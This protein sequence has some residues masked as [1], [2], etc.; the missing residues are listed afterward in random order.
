MLLGKIIN[1]INFVNMSEIK[2]RI[3][4][5]CDAS[6]IANCHWHVRD[7]YSQGIFLSLGEGFLKAYYKV[8]LNEPWEVVICAERE[9]GKIIGFCSNNLNGIE[10]DKNFVKHKFK[11]GLAA[12]RAIILHPHLFKECWIR[13]KA[14]KKASGAP[15]LSSIEG[16]RGEYWC[17]LKNDD[18]YK[19]VEMSQIAENIIYSLGYKD[20]SFEV[21][22][23]NKQVFKYHLKVAKAEP[24]KEIKMPDGRERVMF[25]KK[26]QLK[27]I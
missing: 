1:I 24:V 20:M 10:Q 15:D 14:L 4:K 6:Q 9:D 13:Y 27:D 2:F 7:R 19:S 22:K 21:D 12:M 16:V 8:I 17:W 26:L 11:L 5:P 3:A 25:R 18:S 23:F